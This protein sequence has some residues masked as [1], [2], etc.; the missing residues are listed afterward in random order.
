MGFGI[1]EYHQ[2]DKTH[3]HCGFTKEQIEKIIER[4]GGKIINYKESVE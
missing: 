1:V 3:K 4:A 2:L